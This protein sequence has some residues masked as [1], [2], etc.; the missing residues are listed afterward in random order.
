MNPKF[1][2]VCLDAE[3]NRVEN[4]Q[5]FP[6][7]VELIKSNH[8]RLFDDYSGFCPQDAAARA[9]EFINSCYPCFWAVVDARSREF[10]GFIFLD[11]WVGSAGR[12]HSAAVTTCF[13]KKFWGPFVRRVGR[14]FTRFVFRKFGLIKLRA[15]VFASNPLA[16]RALTSAGFR[17]EA[18][19]HAETFAG[20]VLEDVAVFSLLNPRLAM[21]APAQQRAQTAG[22]AEQG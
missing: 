8:D 5:Y 3:K 6:D 22:A 12:F 15:E 16:R 21:C 10:A 4:V 7:I 19:L 17:L 14:L 18:V 1:L 20:G 11:S 2:R 9:L 13:R